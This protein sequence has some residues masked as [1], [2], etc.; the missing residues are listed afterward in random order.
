MSKF[1]DLTGQR[2]G[3][4]TVVKRVE[5]QISHGGTINVRWLCKCDCLR[6]VVVRA[7]D[8]RSG[9]TQSCGCLH[10]ET[11]THK[12][13]G[14]SN[15]RLCDIWNRI[16]QR[17]YNCKCNDFPYYGGRGIT[18]CDEWLHDFM[19]F[20]NWAISNGYRDNLTIDR[21]DVNGNYDPSNCRWATNK[22]QQNNKRNNRLLTY[23]NKSQTIAQWADE[24]GMSYGKLYNRILRGWSV[25]KSLNTP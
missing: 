23:N 6:E 17:C 25:E 5:N 1:I 21:I 15:S 2:F 9:R 19:L 8:L 4:L 7:K 20:Y 13:H 24:Y 22:A 18:I 3:R 10:S 11:F 12:T 16:K 14:L